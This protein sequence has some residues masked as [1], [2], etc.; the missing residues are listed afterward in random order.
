MV[1]AVH[2]FFGTLTNPISTYKL[3]GAV[4][5]TAAT[6][7]DIVLEIG[8]PRLTQR[9]AGNRTNAGGIVTMASGGAGMPA[10]AAV[11]IVRLQQGACASRRTLRTTVR[12]DAGPVG[13]G[14]VGR[15]G[16]IA[17]SAILR[18]GDRTFAPA[19]TRYLSGSGALT[20]RLFAA[21]GDRGHAVATNGTSVSACPAILRIGG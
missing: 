12:T 18:I 6:V 9:L 1:A 20:G 11:L 21:G 3:L 14:L 19:R 7:H 17:G 2:R 13:A 8:A 10:R 15:A 4:G 16:L 5:I